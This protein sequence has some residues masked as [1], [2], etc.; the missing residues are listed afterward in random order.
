MLIT[1]SQ[2]AEY[3][4]RSM[5][6][7]AGSWA[8]LKATYRFFANPRVD[9]LA[10]GLPHREAT[11]AACVGHQVVL[12][13]Q[14]DSDLSSVKIA[15]EEH[16]MHHTLA[17][18]PEGKLLGIL[19]QRFFAR[20]KKQA[21]E[22]RKQRAERWRESDIWQESVEAI[23][24]APEGTRFIHVAD[25]GAD[26]LRFM[27]ACIAKKTGFVVRAHHDR[28]VDQDTGKLWQTLEQEPVRKKIQVTIGA[29]RGNKPR[30]KRE[31]TLSVRFKQVQLE[32]PWNQ[33]EAHD[34]P[35]V[36]YAVHLVEEEP[37][38][39]VEP[40]D[41]MLL[42]SE[43]VTSVEQA[44]RIIAYYQ[45]RWVI[46]EWHRALKEGC[47]L[48]LS[49]VE[50]IEVLR[51]MTAVL[52]IV[53]VRLLELRDLADSTG[54]SESA[55]ELQRMVPQAWIIIVAALAKTQPQALTP[56][57]F[58]QTIAKRGGW[59]GRK[60]DGRPGWKAIW[61][62]WHDIAQFVTGAELMATARENQNTL[63]RCG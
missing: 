44:Q 50:S 17:V 52:S 29:Q 35:L 31:A 28:R 58:W 15:A 55:Q 3:P 19:Q 2:M 6:K 10:I 47:R 59:L 16:L 5:P 4:E 7:Q 9:E 61:T 43:E 57:K 20:V 40:V 1:A 21:G 63:T 30:R 56:K 48:E 33:H 39:G 42:T 53:A 18:V 38:Q 37:P 62:G 45:C 60:G 14:D 36:V 34:G 32:A 12:C 25:R 11:F 24:D 46:E 22:T 27:H 23:S 26:N 54:A 51:R 13:V 8:D 41:W 49:Q